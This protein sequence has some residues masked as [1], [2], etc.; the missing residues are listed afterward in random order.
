MPR[1]GELNLT[2]MCRKLVQAER[3]AIAAFLRR[4]VA[5]WQGAGRIEVDTLI[6]GIEAGA[7]MRELTPLRPGERDERD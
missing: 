5:E 2:E 3:A 7:H 6:A 1:I 4:H